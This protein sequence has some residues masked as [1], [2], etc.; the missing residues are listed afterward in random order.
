MALCESSTRTYRDGMQVE[1][2]AVT[3]IQM[4]SGLR[5]VMNTGDYVKPSEPDKGTLFR[6]VGTL[7][8]LDFYG[9]ESRYRLLNAANPHGRTFD[10]EPGPGTR[11]QRHLENLAAHIDRG[12]PDY[13]VAESSLKALELCEAAYVSARHGGVTVPLPLEQFAPPSPVDWA[14]GQ[15]YSGQDGGRDGRKLPPG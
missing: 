3:Y 1:T 14:P 4:H 5:V 2:L 9:W 8:T 15:P 11:H 6:L 7:G 10:V 13:S 12:A